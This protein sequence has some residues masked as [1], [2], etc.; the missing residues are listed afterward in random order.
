MQI[1]N[2]G[3]FIVKRQTDISYTL[4]PEDPNLTNY[5]FLHFNQATRI[6]HENEVI[7]A[8]LYYDQKKRLCATMEKPLITTTK[9]GMV[10]VVDYNKAGVFVNIGIAKDI[11][12]STDYLPKNQNLRPKIGEEV[13]CIIKVKT[14]QLVAKIITK[15]DLKIKPEPLKEKTTTSAVV[16][17]ISPS[18]INLYTDQLQPIFVH[19]DLIREKYHIGQRVE[20]RIVHL[21]E[22][23]EANGSLIK[24]KE[25]EMDEDAKAI[26]N[27]LKNLGGM[28]PLGNNS[29]PEQIRKIFPMSKSA[30]KRAVGSLYK[31][32]LITISD[33]K[34]NLVK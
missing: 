10:K 13:P 24:P 33:D 27:Y 18:G 22:H 26:L 4:S 31:K 21:N 20:V 8:F 6:L 32:R 15:D 2:V 30:F 9:P 23:L 14:D 28:L 17:R 7:E 16:S 29:T 1:G 12:L 3:K 19:Q 5:I 11:L 34:I 25:L